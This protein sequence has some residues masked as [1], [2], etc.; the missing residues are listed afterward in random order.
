MSLLGRTFKITDDNYD[1]GCG[2]QEYN[3]T[4]SVCEAKKGEKKMFLKWVYPQKYDKD[5][6]ENYPGDKTFPMSIAVANS[7]EDAI[8]TLL[9]WVAILRGEDAGQNEGSSQKQK[10]E[11]IPPVNDEIPF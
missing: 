8:K 1:S 6:K 2:M 7:K 10:A 11:W 3:G 4:Y 5:T 9:R